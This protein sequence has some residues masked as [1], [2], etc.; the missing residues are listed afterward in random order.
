[1]MSWEFI[2]GISNKYKQEKK[3]TNIYMIEKRSHARRR[4]R[5][6]CQL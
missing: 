2:D 6:R 4:L 5:E 3:N 1:M